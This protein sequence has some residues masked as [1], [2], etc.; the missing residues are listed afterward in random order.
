MGFSSSLFLYV[1]FPISI[2]TFYFLSFFENKVSSIRKYRLTDFLLLFLSIFFY[3]WA[4]PT[5]LLDLCLFIVIVF[6]M[7]WL[8]E[9]IPNEEKKKVIL[10]S[11]GILVAILFW[12]K[13]A[14]S[15]SGFIKAMTGVSLLSVRKILAPLGISFVTF[16]AISYLVDIYRGN[17]KSGNLLDAAIY[18]TFFPKVVSGPIVLYKDFGGGEFVLEKYFRR[19]V[20]TWSKSYCYRVG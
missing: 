1:F 10:V 3:W 4:M 6:V 14:L 13:Y 9:H 11:V 15:V 16:S 7:G 18:L 8:V 20:R 19:Q 2:V 17:A 5:M 12:Y